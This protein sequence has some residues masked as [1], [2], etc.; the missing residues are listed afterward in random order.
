MATSGTTTF[1]SNMEEIINDALSEIN[2]IGEG[3]VASSDDQKRCIR[4]LN[5]MVKAWE[6]K[7]IHLWT[8]TTALVFLQ[9]DQNTYRLASNGDHASTEWGKT[10]LNAAA[11]ITATS[12]TVVSTSGMKVGDYIGVEQSDSTLHWSTIA[13]VPDSTTV[14][15]NDGLTVAANSG[16][17]VWNYTTRLDQPVKVYTANYRSRD[18]RDVPMEN[19]S[20]QTYFELPNKENTGTPVSFNFDKQRDYSILRVWLTPANVNFTLPI[21]FSRKLQDFTDL[22]D[23]PDFPQ[24]WLECIVDNAAIRIA[25]HYG[26]NKGEKFDKLVVRAENGLAEMLDFDNEMGVVRITPD[27][28]GQETE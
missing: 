28:V 1:T 16:G 22:V 2:V 11:V 25:P 4:I 6:G 13:T 9:K 18:A 26:K 19:I 10:T 21:T 27:Y 14:T 12:L 24:E 3:E 7:G 5:R 15:I 23:N 8:K 20:Y 17:L